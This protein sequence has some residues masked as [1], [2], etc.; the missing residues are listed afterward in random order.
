MTNREVVKKWLEA[1]ESG[2][3]DQGT[4]TLRDNTVLPN[5][6]CCLG[7]LCDIVAKEGVGEWKADPDL[8]HKTLF[9]I[10][11]MGSSAVLPANLSLW[12]RLH[13][14]VPKYDAPHLTSSMS[15]KLM[16]LNDSFGKNFSE[17][18]AIIREF[19]EKVELDNS[20]FIKG[21][22]L[23]ETKTEDEEDKDNE[24]DHD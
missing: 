19:Y 7:V 20:E 2:K 15:A 21:Y 6:Y 5:K 16:S 1:L 14:E 13:E 4:L 23:E 8:S 12:L 10:S 24:E 9:R 17:I 18:S 11:G 22:T 3:Y